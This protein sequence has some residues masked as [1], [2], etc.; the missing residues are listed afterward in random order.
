[1]KR[2]TKRADIALRL[3]DELLSSRKL[4]RTTRLA[5]LKLRRELQEIREER[6]VGK[7]DFA[8]IAMRWAVIVA[9]LY[10]ILDRLAE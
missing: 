10:E 3:V 5:L 2:A 7:R 6:D 1:M 4:Q 8:G 9:K